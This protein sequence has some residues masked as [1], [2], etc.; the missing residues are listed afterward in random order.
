MYSKA[1]WM[2]YFQ[3]QKFPT[4]TCS[5]INT[6]TH[7]VYLT[8][9]YTLSDGV[10]ERRLFIMLFCLKLVVPII[11]IQLELSI[12]DVWC[13]NIR[14]SPA[15]LKHF[16]ANSNKNAKQFSFRHLIPLDSSQV[17]WSSAF[18][19]AS[20]SGYFSTSMVE[21]NENCVNVQWCGAI[22]V[23]ILLFEE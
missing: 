14:I 10:H 6:R 2:D 1:W 17:M 15:I 7:S 22:D 19:A 23:D 12:L 8:L 18:A 9:M 4:N 5:N 3:H 11:V 20:S 13:M 21:P 16:P